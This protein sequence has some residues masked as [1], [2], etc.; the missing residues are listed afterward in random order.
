MKHRIFLTLA[1]TVSLFLAGFS[2]A[3]QQADFFVSKDKKEYA[4]KVWEA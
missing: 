2:L 4:P 1:L 3:A